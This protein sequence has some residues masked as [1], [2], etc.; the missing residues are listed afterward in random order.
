[1]L[2]QGE[3]I[4]T[5]VLLLRLLESHDLPLLRQGERIETLTR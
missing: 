5:T 1:M 3:R 2:R 4:E